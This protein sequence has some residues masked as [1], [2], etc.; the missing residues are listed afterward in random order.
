MG[1]HAARAGYCIKTRF[2]HFECHIPPFTR[3]P[4]HV[5]FFY[6][7]GEKK[8]QTLQR[9]EQPDRT[10]LSLEDSLVR[11]PFSILGLP[12]WATHKQ[13]L[14]KYMEIL[15]SS[16]DQN[17]LCNK[18]AGILSSADTRANA[19]VDTSAECREARTQ[20]EKL[21]RASISRIETE[22][23][24]IRAL[25]MDPQESQERPP[26]PENPAQ[27]ACP[28]ALLGLPLGV[29]AAKITERWEHLK[30]NSTV[31]S[32]A[33]TNILTVARDRALALVD[34]EP[35]C[36][37]QH[38]W[39]HTVDK[40]VQ[41]SAIIDAQMAQSK[42][43]TPWL[44]HHF[45]VDPLAD[46]PFLILGLPPF[47]TAAEVMLKAGNLSRDDPG[48]TAVY[49]SARDRA[50]QNDIARR[51]ARDLNPVEIT[52]MY[53]EAEEGRMS[54]LATLRLH[55]LCGMIPI[56]ARQVCWLFIPVILARQAANT[57]VR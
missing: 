51:N 35:N 34:S 32:H 38:K 45:P 37:A 26:V 55:P 3:D 33:K 2:S 10:P 19:M 31:R 54:Y 36:A 8:T 15:N 12:L 6:H 1:I 52:R 13:I 41:M 7:Q 53:S 40:S 50:Q 57:R 18:R 30:D 4:I 20:K 21:C 9:K 5:N 27:T 39:M 23:E 11:C 44:T 29:T 14:T 48:R 24:R 25:I 46:C 17:M 16:I 47:V 22:A 49:E 42:L 43:L 28:F 56:V